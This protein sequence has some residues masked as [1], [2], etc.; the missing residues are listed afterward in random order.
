[1]KSHQ[2]IRFKSTNTK[3]FIGI[4]EVKLVLKKSN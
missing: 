3:T 2:V 4:N 1:M